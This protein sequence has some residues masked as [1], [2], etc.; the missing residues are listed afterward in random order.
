[1]PT[2][3]RRQ[4]KF[5]T[6][7]D[8]LEDAHKMAGPH[9]KANGGWTTAQVISHVAIFLHCSVHGFDFDLP[10]PMRLFGRLMRN[11]MLKKGFPAGIKIP[12]K[13]HPQFAPR[14]NVTLDQAMA[15]LTTAI[16][17]AKQQGM[18][19][20]SPLFGRLSQKQW[21]QLHC[22]HAELHF[23]FIQPT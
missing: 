11:R 1:M 4:I 8:L 7:D 9:T 17:D 22:R 12:G 23:S 10:L 3:I 14:V 13:A 15:Q 21:T 5:D 6:L 16:Q 2:P 19:I 20:V 18:N